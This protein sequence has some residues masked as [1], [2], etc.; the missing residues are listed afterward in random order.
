MAQSG[1]IHGAALCSP[2]TPTCRSRQGGA[3]G[4]M[5]AARQALAGALPRGPPWPG[6]RLSCVPAGR[7]LRQAAQLLFQLAASKPKV[8]DE[9][10]LKM[11]AAAVAAA[12]LPPAEGGENP[13]PFVGLVYALA[14]SDAGCEELMKSR[15]TMPGLLPF[16]Q[17]RSS[18]AE[19]RR[20]P[21]AALPPS[22]SLGVGAGKQ[23]GRQAV[24]LLPYCV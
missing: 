20:C 23:A 24:R 12:A 4:G 13:A 9:M 7:P 21:A 2:P 18:A 14:Q 3:P 19:V 6:P 22:A 15:K 17:C 5:G 10:V 1:A 16:L 11:N 8:R